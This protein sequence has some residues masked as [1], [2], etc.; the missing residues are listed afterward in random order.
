MSLLWWKQPTP[1]PA[2]VAAA[3]SAFESKLQEFFDYAMVQAADGL[4]FAEI[5]DLT[6]KF[7]AVAVE[8]ANELAIP[9]ADKKA[10]VMDAVTV[11]YDSLTVFL[12]WYLRVLAPF[13]R[14]WVLEWIDGQIEAVLAFIDARLTPEGAK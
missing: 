13:V 7:I 1:P 8:A 11:L 3:Q 2:I 9:G 14:G 5:S 12:P 10:L 4:T 6:G